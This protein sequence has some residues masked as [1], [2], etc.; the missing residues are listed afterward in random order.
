MDTVKPSWLKRPLPAGPIYRAT[1]RILDQAGAPTVCRESGCPNLW[2]CF[3]AGTATFLILGDRCTRGCRFCGIMP[4][5]PDAPDP[6]EPARVAEAVRLLGLRHV[7]ITSVTRDD[8]SDGGAGH[9]AETVTTARLAVP[10]IR[11]ETLVPDFQG[12]DESLRTLARVR[13]DIFAHNLDTVPRLFPSIRPNADYR[14]SLQVLR[15]FGEIAPG[16]PRKSGLMLG[17]GESREEIET[18]LRDLLDAGCRLLTIGQYLPPSAG[19]APVRRYVPPEE[20]DAW[21][22]FAEDMG[23]E[24]AICGPLVRSSYRAGEHA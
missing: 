6:D 9:F 3:S 14:R 8:L 24:R 4:G 19:N 22:R 2:E 15:T 1:R 23:F 16:I 11:V 20:F 13:P 12:S 10:G 18:A 21:T 17:L 5:P 7:V